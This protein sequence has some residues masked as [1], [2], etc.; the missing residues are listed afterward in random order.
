LTGT[1][2]TDSKANQS[3]SWTARINSFLNFG[4]NTELQIMLFYFSPTVGV[5]GASGRGFHGSSQGRTRENYFVNLGAKRNFMDGKV[6][7]FVRVSDIFKTEK[8]GQI[9]YGNDFKTTSVRYRESQVIYFGVSFKINEG[10]KQ[11]E[12]KSEDEN[13]DIDTDEL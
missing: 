8:H 12:K 2:I 4:K 11:R 1:G 3:S 7:V 9:V 6:S 10:I 5:S 13:N